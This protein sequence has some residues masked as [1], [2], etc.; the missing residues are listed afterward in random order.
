RRGATP[1]HYAC[2]PRPASGG[3]WDPA[4]QAA[5]VDL[6]VHHGAHLEHVDRGG[7]SALHRAVRARSPMAV[8]HLLE[9]GARVDGRLTKSGSTTLHLAVH[10]TGAGGTAGAL[11][12]QLEIIALLLDHGADPAMPDATGTSAYN[13]ARSDRVREALQK[14]VRGRSRRQ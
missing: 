11:T 7:A 1:L 2:D 12:E 3:A 5:I 8:R 13:G 4:S 9:A 6:L 10:S 14:R